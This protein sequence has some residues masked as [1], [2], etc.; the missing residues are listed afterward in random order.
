MMKNTTEKIKMIFEMETGDPD[1]Y[2]TLLFLIGHPK[3]DLIGVNVNPGGWDQVSIVKQAF[4]RFGIMNVPV[5]AFLTSDDSKNRVSGWHFKSAGL[6][7]TRVAPDIEGFNLLNQLYAED[8]TLITGSPLKNVGKFLTEFPDRKL[9]RVIVQ[10][11]F[12]GEGVVPPEIQMEKFKGLSSVPSYNL[13]G[14]IKSAIAVIESPNFLEKK[15]VS[16]NVCHGVLFD[17]QI[18][19][20]IYL[21]L[22]EITKIRRLDNLM[23][24]RYLNIFVNSCSE[25]KKLHDLLA[26]ACAIDTSIGTW[27]KVNMSRV[28]GGWMSELNDHSNLEVIINYDKNKF[29]NVLTGSFA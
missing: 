15:F 18:K 1:D 17:E 16:K 13:N 19:K 14:D 3:V 25:G 23:L 22:H 24:Q 9:G 11:G 10:G 4:K 7:N 12:A 5:G 26:A 8:V 29:V 6:D 27:A 2:L 21:K 20:S 28:N